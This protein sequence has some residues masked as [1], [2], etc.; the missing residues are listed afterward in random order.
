MATKPTTDTPPGAP[1]YFKPHDFLM[2]NCGTDQKANLVI[3]R[4]YTKLPCAARQDALLVKP[5]IAT[6]FVLACVYPWL[7]A[8]LMRDLVDRELLIEGESFEIPGERPHW[9]TKIDMDGF[10]LQ[11]KERPDRAAQ[12]LGAPVIVWML[13]KRYK[14]NDKI[15]LLYLP[16]IELI[17]PTANKVA[18]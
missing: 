17:V 12:W 14:R 6:K 10:N 9:I 13:I 11:T 4:R 3:L 1:K 8:N 7:A 2:P 15:K 5:E 18:A 16:T